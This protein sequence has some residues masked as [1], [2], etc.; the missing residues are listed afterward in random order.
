MVNDSVFRSSVYEH[1]LTKE[2]HDTKKTE[3]M[4]I[5]KNPYDHLNR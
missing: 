4:I 1:I 5:D 2:T 3:L